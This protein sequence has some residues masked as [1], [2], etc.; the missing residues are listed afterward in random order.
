MQIICL[1]I[2]CTTFVPGL[3]GIFDP[4]WS[5]SWIP[6][7]GIWVDNCTCTI[8]LP[9]WCISRWWYS[10]RLFLS[11]FECVAAG[12]NSHVVSFYVLHQR[13]FATAWNTVKE[14][15]LQ[16]II[17]FFWI[18]RMLLYTLKYLL[19]K[20]RVLWKG[21]NSEAIH[22][23]LRIQTKQKLHSQTFRGEQGCEYHC[24]QW[25]Y[26]DLN[27]QSAQGMQILNWTRPN[28]HLYP[29]CFQMGVHDITFIGHVK[30][31]TV[32]DRWRQISSIFCPFVMCW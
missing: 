17:C 26:G 10:H 4:F 12:V 14:F 3:V 16:W 19:V 9:S 6:W 31:T 30:I 22:L 25:V 28:P 29:I 18:I 11:H 8:T 23:P 15:F 5:W 2:L 21:I 24:A 20:P 32:F 13:H 27:S 7:V 1:W